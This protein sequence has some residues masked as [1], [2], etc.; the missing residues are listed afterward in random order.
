MRKNTI[1]RATAAESLS[2]D[3]LAVYSV[4]TTKAGGIRSVHEYL[5]TGTGEI[6]PADQLNIPVLDLRERLPARAKALASLRFEVQQFATFV[7][8]FANLRRGIT[9]GIGVLCQWY[10]E[11]HSRR[12]QDVRRYIPALHK[13]GVLAG[14][15]LLGPLFQRTGGKAREHLGEEYRAACIYSR[16]R[17]K[18]QPISTTRT[19]TGDAE[20]IATEVSQLEAQREADRVAWEWESFHLEQPHLGQPVHALQG[21]GPCR[22]GRAAS[23]G[24]GGPC[25]VGKRAISRALGQGTP[26]L[27]Q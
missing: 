9:P 8:R 21:C 20:V 14:E 19:R 1:S 17:M 4:N 5:D 23:D 7:L 18:A 10:A 15:T 6:I 24:H 3:M 16:L 27:L 2:F 12:S 25:Q 22:S 13:A 26:R 11:M